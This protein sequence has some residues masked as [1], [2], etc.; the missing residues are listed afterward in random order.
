[1]NPSVNAGWNV[2]R[3]SFMNVGYMVLCPF[4]IITAKCRCGKA[5]TL[6]KISKIMLHLIKMGVAHSHLPEAGCMGRQPIIPPFNIKQWGW[7]CWMLSWFIRQHLQQVNS[8]AWSQLPLT[9]L[10]RTTRWQN[11]TTLLQPILQWLITFSSY[12]GDWLVHFGVRTFLCFCKCNA[13]STTD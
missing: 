2:N 10:R 9:V 11:Q 1:M 4:R 7:Y 12:G 8:G 13:G 6:D 5:L 3:C